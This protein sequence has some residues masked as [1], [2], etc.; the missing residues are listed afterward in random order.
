MGSRMKNFNIIQVHWKIQFLGGVHKK[1]IYRGNCLKGRLGEFADLR[2]GGLGEKEG[3]YV[4][5]PQC[6]LCL[7]MEMCIAKYVKQNMVNVPTDKRQSKLSDTPKLTLK[8][9]FMPPFYGWGSTSSRLEPL[10]GGSLVFTTK[11]PEIPGERLSRIWSHPVVLNTG[12][13]DW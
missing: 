13:L 2:G 3:A 9:N 4:I 7:K 6:I 1:P 8:K 5:K 12:L 11:S 10:Q